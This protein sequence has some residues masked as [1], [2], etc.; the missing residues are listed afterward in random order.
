MKTMKNVLM[1]LL[2][3]A[4]VLSLAGVGAVAAADGEDVLN[5]DK[6]TGALYVTYTV[7]GGYSV[8]IPTNVGITGDS[9]SSTIKVDAT[10]TEKETLTVTAKSQNEWQMRLV[11]AVDGSGNPTSYDSNYYVAY[12]LEGEGVELL[13]DTKEYRIV[14]LNAAA[15]ATFNPLT[16]TIVKDDATKAI[17]AGNYK[18]MITFTLSVT[19][20]GTQA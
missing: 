12:H 1:I 2:G 3:A 5:V 7:T 15:A 9:A 19:E 4:L 6:K 11:T 13:Q 20:V 8:T 10:L 16:L 18:D 17:A 14:T